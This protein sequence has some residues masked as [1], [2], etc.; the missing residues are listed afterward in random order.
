MR[1]TSALFIGLS[2]ALLL[3]GCVSRDDADMQL[4][5]ACRAGVQTLLPQNLKIDRI[6]GRE[7]SKSPEGQDMRYIK[8][9]TVTID[10]MLEEDKDYE[11]IFEED[12]GMFGMGYT[13]SV[14]QVRTGDAMYGRSG[15]ELKG[16]AEIFLK[17][18]DA[19]RNAL[20][21]PTTYND[22]V[23]ANGETGEKKE[24]DDLNASHDDAPTPTPAP[25]AGDN[26]QP[27]SGTAGNQ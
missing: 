21:E 16:D 13:A 1:N 4:A 3:T 12:F 25:A 18:T 15:N 5:H 24:Q 7:A 22:S 23:G 20:Y 6:V 14:Y 26:N 17:L 2:C 19:M 8:I 9:K 10:G 27:A 11:C